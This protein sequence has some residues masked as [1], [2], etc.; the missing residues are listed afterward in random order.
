MGV[1]SAFCCQKESPV[2]LS[3]VSS[4]VC[5]IQHSP[6]SSVTRR[7]SVAQ[8]GWTPGPVL[9]RL[10]L[11]SAVAGGLLFE[12]PLRWGKC[13]CLS[14]TGMLC[15][16][17]GACILGSSFTPDP[18]PLVTSFMKCHVPFPQAFLPEDDEGWEGAACPCSQRGQ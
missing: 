4:K 17:E 15:N 10:A 14:H 2:L 3:R 5:A 7:P 16:P 1:C 18:Q 6:F 11:G 13:F 9:Q 8:H 12:N